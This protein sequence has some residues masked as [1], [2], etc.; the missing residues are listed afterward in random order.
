MRWQRARLLR[1][2]RIEG[3]PGGPPA[4]TLVWVQGPPNELRTTMT[5][6]GRLVERAVPVR[7]YI[8]NIRW[9]GWLEARLAGMPGWQ[10]ADGKAW[11]GIAPEIV[12]LLPEFCDDPPAID[13]AWG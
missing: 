7:R 5:M 6:T 13:W 9:P 1:Q 4:G 11:L 8:V 2:A 12:E 3:R 10:S